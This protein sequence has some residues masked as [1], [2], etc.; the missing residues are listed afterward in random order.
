MHYPESPKVRQQCPNKQQPQET[1]ISE[2][3]AKVEF[4][5]VENIFESPE[6]DSAASESVKKDAPIIVSVKAMDN[7]TKAS[8]ETNPGEAINLE[9]N[10]LNPTFDVSP[11]DSIE[12]TPWNKTCEEVVSTVKSGPLFARFPI[13]DYVTQ[14]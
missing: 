13:V 9:Q 4:K 12:E 14:M 5:W 11:K 10:N 8:K 1:V 3:Q 6:K 7:I 2:H